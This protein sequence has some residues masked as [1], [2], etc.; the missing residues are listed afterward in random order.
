MR[1]AEEGGNAPGRRRCGRPALSVEASSRRCHPEIASSAACFRVEGAV[2]A[3][4]PLRCFVFLQSIAE[5]TS[6][7]TGRFLGGT[8]VPVS[9]RDRPC[10][11]AGVGAGIEPATLGFT[12]R[13]STHLSYPVVDEPDSNRWPTACAAALP[14]SYRPLEEHL[15]PR[16]G[17]RHGSAA[18]TGRDTN[19][20]RCSVFD[21]CSALPAVANRQSVRAPCALVVSIPAPLASKHHNAAHMRRSQP[22][23]CLGARGRATRMLQGGKKLRGGMERTWSMHAHP[24]R[25]LETKRPRDLRPEGVR[26]PREI[27]VTDLPGSQSDVRS[28]GTARVRYRA[29][30]RRSRAAPCRSAMAAGRACCRRNR[31]AS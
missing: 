12:V 26:V 5:R 3:P 2:P 29:D 23:P 30:S 24:P 1:R 9:W 14:L 27:G 4:S 28:A 6:R 31:R 25:T 20:Y 17:I 7:C 13:C 22:R 16:F 18:R 19:P 21:R 10:A 8:F 15:L 11:L